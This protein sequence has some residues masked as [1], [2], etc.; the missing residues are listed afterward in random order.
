ML[1][2]CGRRRFSSL[3]II[4]SSEWAT[5]KRIP[6]PF[7]R[8]KGAF[9]SF[10]TRSDLRWRRGLGSRLERIC[11]QF[12]GKI[13]SH[14]RREENSPGWERQASHLSVHR[15]NP[16]SAKCFSG[17]EPGPTEGEKLS[18]CT[19]FC[20]GYL[21]AKMVCCVFAEGRKGDAQHEQTKGQW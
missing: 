10:A 1:R 3:H 18:V 13:R 14:E 17:R 5:L 19:Q 16:A 8:K 21:A 15:A 6:G 2:V 9:L 7:S 4:S 20:P 12:Q 11:Q